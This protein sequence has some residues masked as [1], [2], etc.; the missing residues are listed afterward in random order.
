MREDISGK[1]E[2]G[3]RNGGKGGAYSTTAA[4]RGV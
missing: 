4:E 1:V 3:W 2:S